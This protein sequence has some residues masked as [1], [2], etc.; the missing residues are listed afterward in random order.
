MLAGAY[1][2]N[3]SH[4]R[5]CGKTRIEEALL[6]ARFGEAFLDYQRAVSAYVP[7]LNYSRRKNARASGSSPPT[8]LSL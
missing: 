2:L 1:C 3:A 4:T 6:A 8:I 5:C 7:F